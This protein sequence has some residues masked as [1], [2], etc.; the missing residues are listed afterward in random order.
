M[1]PTSQGAL[2]A[3]TSAPV[4]QRAKRIPRAV[5]AFSVLLVLSRSLGLSFSSVLLAGSGSGRRSDTRTVRGG[6]GGIGIGIG[7][8]AAA[9]DLDGVLLIPME[10]DMVSP[11]DM[12]VEPP[13]PPEMPKGSAEPSGEEF[14]PLE[15]LDGFDAPKKAPEGEGTSP[16]SEAVPA[17]TGLEISVTPKS[18][19]GKKNKRWLKGRGSA[20][21]RKLEENSAL[22]KWLI[23]NGVW[24]S[25][26]A[27]WG[28]EA[29]AVSI[30][31]ETRESIENENTGR[32]LVARRDVNMY[33]QLARIPYD[34]LMTKEKAQSVFGEDCIDSGMSEYTAIAILL[35]EEKYAKKESSFWKP[36]LDVLPTTEEIGASFT[37]SNEDLDNLLAGSPARNMSYFLKGKVLTELDTIKENVVAKYPD[38]LTPEIYTPENFMWAYAILTSRSVR[39]EYEDRDDSDI[40]LVPLLDLINHNPDMTTCI[41]AELEGV[42]L[43]MGLETQERCVVALADKYYDKY[44]QIYISYGQKSNAQLMMLYGFSMER[45]TADYLEIPVGQLVET[46]EMRE[47]KV[48]VMDE[49]KL[50]REVYPLYRDRF[51]QSMMVF[52]RLVTATREELNLEDWMGEEYEYRALRTMDL[53][54][55]SRELSERRCL[56]ALRGIVQDV[57]DAYPTTIQDDEMLIKDRA[58]FELL[59]KNQRNALRVRYS[60]KLILRATLTSLD[61]TMNNLGRLTQMELEKEKAWEENRK[62]PWGRLGLSIEPTWTST[63]DLQ[64]FVKELDM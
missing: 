36:Y 59:P 45:N 61:K 15:G 26:A 9:D 53:Q 40:S 55:A 10:D 43:P 22:E 30:A 19:G 47:A 49:I 63:K 13:A 64:D 25:D 60:E 18:T 1:T 38:R 5:A 42:K 34:L 28:R 4:Q 16:R 2:C 44:E 56:I 52:L 39:L 23:E 51:T 58:M 24:V 6:G 31:V 50:E 3:R 62:T 11:E 17:P 12:D 57:L 27:D 21:R 29:S 33:E 14:P 54:V 41:A 20:K 37:W 48:R 32:G 8:R 35:I 7:R 46:A